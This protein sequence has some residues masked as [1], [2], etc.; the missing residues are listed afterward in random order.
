MD[1]CTRLCMVCHDARVCRKS[2]AS[3][4]SLERYTFTLTVISFTDV[5]ASGLLWP[6]AVIGNARWSEWRRLAMLDKT[7]VNLYITPFI[8]PCRDR[9]VL[10]YF[11]P[12]HNTKVYLLNDFISWPGFFWLLFYRTLHPKL[13]MEILHFVHDDREVVQD[14]LCKNTQVGPMFSG[15]RSESFWL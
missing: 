13:R 5:Q 8:Y 11:L 3:W 1:M 12:G 15:K 14:Y 2:R 4:Q 7:G 6:N 9:A 10:W